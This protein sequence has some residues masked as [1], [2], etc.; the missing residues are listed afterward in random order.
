MVMRGFCRPGRIASGF[1]TELRAFCL[2]LLVSLTCFGCATNPAWLDSPEAVAVNLSKQIP[3]RG[4]GHCLTH[5]LAMQKRFGGQVRTIE[6]SMHPFVVHA[7][8]VMDDATVYDNG[9]LGYKT[10]W[11]RL[12]SDGWRLTQNVDN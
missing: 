12:V 1:G 3:S 8:L 4:G 6:H 5:A 11:K 9:W 2:A 10:T 7:V